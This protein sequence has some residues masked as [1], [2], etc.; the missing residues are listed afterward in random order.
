L[1]QTLLRWNLTK[2]NPKFIEQSHIGLET[3]I[4]LPDF[5]YLLQ[6]F[7]VIVQA[8]V[9]YVLSHEPEYIRWLAIVYDSTTTTEKELQSVVDGYLFLRESSMQGC[10]KDGSV[11]GVRRRRVYLNCRPKNCVLSWLNIARNPYGSI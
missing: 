4:N 8:H 1:V 11:F 3:L 10:R 5:G 2:I 6:A 9:I 7:H